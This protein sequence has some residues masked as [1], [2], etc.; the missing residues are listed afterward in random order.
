MAAI[1]GTSD[2]SQVQANIIAYFDPQVVSIGGFSSAD[3]FLTAT[4]AGK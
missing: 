3:R 2:P 1:Y 4:P